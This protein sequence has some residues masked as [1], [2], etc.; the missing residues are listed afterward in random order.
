MT[1]N[2]N[3]SPIVNGLAAQIILDRIDFVK[4]RELLMSSVCYANLCN[5]GLLSKEDCED[6]V[7]DLLEFFI[8]KTREGIYD[9]SI[10]TPEQYIRGKHNNR[11]RGY[12]QALSGKK[13]CL[14]PLPETSADADAAA[15]EDCGC[16]IVLSGDFYGV[17]SDIFR[18][19]IV[20]DLLDIVNNKI[21]SRDKAVIGHLTE[22]T[23]RMQM[24]E[25][26]GLSQNATNKLV[27][28][29]RKRFRTLLEARGYSDLMA[30]VA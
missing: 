27:H 6:K 26:L 22:E 30:R 19:E 9:P 8:T 24:Q 7:Q 28:D 1:R 5:G 25:E 12:V 17:G 4:L 15:D 20:N 18:D 10:G 16:T 21:S 14:K 13:A 11:I 23:P 29:V 2:S 3:T